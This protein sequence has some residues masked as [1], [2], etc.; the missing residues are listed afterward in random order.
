M[1]RDRNGKMWSMWAAQGWSKRARGEKACFES[2]WSKYFESG[3]EGALRGEGCDKNWMQG[4][5]DWPHY[6]RPAPAL[7][8]FDET[9][10]AYCSAVNGQKEGPFFQFNVELARR[11]VQANQNVLRVL[12]GWNMC[13][14]L[15][16][17]FC[18]MKGL[19]HGQRNRQMRFSIA[20]KNLDVNTFRNPPQCENDRNHCAH[21]YAIS[22][23]YYAEV[24]VVSHVCRNRARLFSLEVGELFECDIDEGAFR[25]L[26]ELLSG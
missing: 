6:P 26:R 17:Q 5:H 8:G 23:V 3:F 25:E 22:D 4:T 19:L 20:P 7:L 24:C 18:A 14:N 1:L 11:C 13:T 21:T 9:I 15:A 10:Y 2:G 16:W 12:S